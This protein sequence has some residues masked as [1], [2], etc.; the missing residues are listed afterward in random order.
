[1]D[2]N[3]PRTHAAR[4]EMVINTR[5]VLHSLLVLPNTTNEWQ[6]FLGAL[7]VLGN[8]TLWENMHIDGDGE[9]IREG[10]L[11]GTLSIAHDGSFMQEELVDL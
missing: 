7:H 8:P 3:L 10:L 11:H 4:V 1:M 2:G 5:A 6:I 9:W